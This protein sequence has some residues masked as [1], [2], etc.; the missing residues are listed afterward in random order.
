MSSRSPSAD[1]AYLAAR[2]ELKFG[3]FGADLRGVK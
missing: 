1:Y 3:F 2:S